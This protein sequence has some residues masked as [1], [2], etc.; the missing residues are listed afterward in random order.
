MEKVHWMPICLPLSADNWDT[1][2]EVDKQFGKWLGS[3]RPL[4]YAHLHAFDV[5]C[6]YAQSV[7]VWL[8]SVSCSSSSTCMSSCL[9][10][11]PTATQTCSS[12]TYISISCGESVPSCKYVLTV[13]YF[14][15]FNFPALLQSSY[16]CGL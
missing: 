5:S 11:A 3:D 2:Q 4:E 12:N 10:S 15:I 14:S 16:I 9:A 7:P 8:T 13:Q 6:R 1:H